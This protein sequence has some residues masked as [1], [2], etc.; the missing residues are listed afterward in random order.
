VA[1]DDVSNSF[2]GAHIMEAIRAMAITITSAEL[3]VAADTV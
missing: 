1:I 3:A 2:P